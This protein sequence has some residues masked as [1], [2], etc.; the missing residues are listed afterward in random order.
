M[1]LRSRSFSVSSIPKHPRISFYFSSDNFDPVLYYLGVCSIVSSTSEMSFVK[2]Y[3]LVTS[4]LIKLDCN[5]SRR[6]PTIFWQYVWSVFSLRLFNI[7]RLL[8]RRNLIVFVYVT[9]QPKSC[10]W[11]VLK[12]DNHYPWQRVLK[13][14]WLSSRRRSVVY[15]Y[16]TLAWQ[17]RGQKK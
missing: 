11:Y 8:I 6:Y 14:R 13:F 1:F 15:S 2:A 3:S 16:S 4:S 7:G 9:L 12:L 5:I 10:G 17:Y